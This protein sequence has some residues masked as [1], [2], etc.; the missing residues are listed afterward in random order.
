MTSHK[1]QNALPVICLLAE[2]TKI[3]YKHGKAD[4]IGYPISVVCV[5]GSDV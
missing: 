4:A 3:P 2:A 1:F 5:S